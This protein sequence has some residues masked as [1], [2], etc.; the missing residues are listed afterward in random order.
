MLK[1]YL[2]QPKNKLNNPFIS[3]VINHFLPAAQKIKDYYI[4][5]FTGEIYGQLL[6][7]APKGIITKFE[8]HSKILIESLKNRNS[9]FEERITIYNMLHQLIKNEKYIVFKEIR[10]QGSASL[11]NKV[12][13]EKGMT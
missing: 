5:N 13:N 3:E 11:F 8:K 7:I 1:I 12:L 9:V 6:K 2:W 10:I 4:S